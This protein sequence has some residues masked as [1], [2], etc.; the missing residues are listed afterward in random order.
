MLPGRLMSGEY[1]NTVEIPVV[2]TLP[3]VALLDFAGSDKQVT[4]IPGKGAEQII[5][6]STLDKTWINYS[7]IVEGLSTNAIS[8][9]ISSG[10]LP[11]EVIV[12]LNVG[13]DAGAG[14]GMVGKPVGQITLSSN[15]QEII[16]GIGSC[17]TGRGICKGH[18]LIYS[19]KWQ[20]PYD[21]NQTLMDSL[22]IA[23]TYTL[24]STK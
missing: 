4:Y 19:W 5:T 10:N 12:K 17:Y 8:V 24:T 20:P 1:N 15:P 2:L 11:P 13:P 16:T 6:P 14:A 7:S 9:S 22:E 18:Q 3:A 23:V 21:L